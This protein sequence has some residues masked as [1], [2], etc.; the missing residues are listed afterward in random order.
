MGRKN[1]EK[2]ERFYRGDE[3]KIC[4][5]P[6]TVKNKSGYCRKHRPFPKE[7]ALKISKSLMGEDNPN[8]KGDS[9]GLNGLHIWIKRNFNKPSSC[10]RCL[11]KP[12]YDL[13]NK[14]IYNRDIKNWE[15]LCRKCHM[16]TDG[17]LAILKRIHRGKYANQD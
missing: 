13:A 5:I 15:W 10:Q 8:W 4:N 2:N 17:R 1:I 9:V 11:V 6:V 16:E 3:C 7:T 14:G 12:P